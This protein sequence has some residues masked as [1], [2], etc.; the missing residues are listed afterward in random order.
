M[1]TVDQALNRIRET[2]EQ[3]DVLTSLLPQMVWVA[4]R[5]ILEE[6]EAS[7]AEQWHEAILAH[8]ARLLE[9]FEQ[10]WGV[11]IKEELDGC[12]KR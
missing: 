11:K 1:L 8:R 6:L 9:E 7:P 2:I 5:R 12:T 4:V 3:R 10:R